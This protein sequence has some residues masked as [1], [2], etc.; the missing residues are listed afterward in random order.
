MFDA[1]LYKKKLIDIRAH[2]TTK[3]NKKNKEI[4]KK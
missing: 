3:K 2:F 1:K 4:E